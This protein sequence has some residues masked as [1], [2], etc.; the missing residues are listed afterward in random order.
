M[1][2]KIILIFFILVVILAIGYY[3]FYYQDGYE[4][5]RCLD[6]DFELINHVCYKLDIKKPIEYSDRF[7]MRYRCPDGYFSPF[8][9]V[10]KYDKCKRHVYVMPDIELEKSIK[11][12]DIVGRYV[13]IIR[14][15]TKIQFITFDFDYNGTGAFSNDTRISSTGEEYSIKGD[16]SYY[17]DGKTVIAYIYYSDRNY[18]EH[19]FYYDNAGDI[20]YVLDSS[21]LFPL[22]KLY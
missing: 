15:N 9:N 10:N 2:K 6:D 18:T 17:I 8:T 1:K 16:I 3:F 5:Y 11:E 21:E 20:F 7:G 13:W 4:Y 19:Y 14:D 12:S 22:Q